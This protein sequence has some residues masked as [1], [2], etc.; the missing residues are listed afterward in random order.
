VGRQF[1]SSLTDEYLEIK[2][3]FGNLENQR[4]VEIVPVGSRWN[5]FKV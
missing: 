4:V 2:I 3:E 5:D 1:V